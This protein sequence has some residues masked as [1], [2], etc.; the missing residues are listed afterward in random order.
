MSGGHFE[1]KNDYVNDIADRIRSD[2]AKMRLKLP[3]YCNYPDDFIALVSQ[4]HDETRVLAAKLHRLDWVLSDDDG[5]EDYAPRLAQDLVGFPMDD[6]S[7][8][9]DWAHRYGCYCE[10]CWS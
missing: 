6:P 9:E 8:D 5:P 2:L 10:D 4:I 7:E 1:Y 3:Y